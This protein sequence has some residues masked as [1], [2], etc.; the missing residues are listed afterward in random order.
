MF[1][2]LIREQMIRVAAEMEHRA[3]TALL[4]AYERSCE[5]WVR[6]EGILRALYLPLPPVPLPPHK[7]RVELNNAP[8]NGIKVGVTSEL[9]TS[10]TVADWMPRFGTDLNAVGGP[11]GGPMLDVTGRETGRFHQASDDRASIGT[12]HVQTSGP[13]AG[14]YVK[15]GTNPFNVFWVKLA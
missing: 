13:R 3:N 9:L 4:A 1:E 12:L 8:D 14:Q 2:E 5:D 11:L 6:N 15:A 10:K 7:L